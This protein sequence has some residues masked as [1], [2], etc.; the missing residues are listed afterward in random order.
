MGYIEENLI[1]GESVVY[2]TRLHWAVLIYPSVFAMFFGLPGLMMFIGSVALLGDKN[3][4]SGGI[5]LLGLFFIG[6]AA[7]IIGLA[8]WYR[9][10]VEIAVTTKRVMMKSGLISRRTGE[11][12]LSKVESINVDQSMFGRVLNYG[13]ITVRGTGGTPE[14][15]SKINHPLEFRRQVQQQLEQLQKPVPATVTT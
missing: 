1:G 11:L 15:F 3:G 10:S 9:S 2:K 12:M 13:T 4:G 7:G 6:I 14:P 8:L 5:A